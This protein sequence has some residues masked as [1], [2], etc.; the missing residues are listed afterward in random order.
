[1]GDKQFTVVSSPLKC[2]VLK[3]S[4]PRLDITYPDLGPTRNP[5]IVIKITI[6]KTCMM[7]LSLSSLSFA[8]RTRRCP[9]AELFDTWTKV[10][11]SAMTE[12]EEDAKC[13]TL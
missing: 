1:M 3:A 5:N 12:S 6:W 8:M 7:I 4:T 9:D 11:K 2:R 10:K 13:I